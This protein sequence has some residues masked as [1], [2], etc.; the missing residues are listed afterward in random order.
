MSKKTLFLIFALFLIAFTLL[1]V[2]IYQPQAPKT[3]QVTPTPVKKIISQS[4]LSFGSPSLDASSSASTPTYSYP[5]NISTGENKVTAVQLE[6][7]YDPKIMTDVKVI[8]GPFFKNPDTLLNQ[9]DAATGRISYALSVGLTAQGITGTGT[10]AN[11]TFSVKDKT[12]EKVAIIFLPK[13]LIT[14]TG[15]TQSVLKQTTNGLFT[16]VKESSTPSAR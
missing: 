1:I 15:E 2:A 5:V 6:L 3:T 8:P 7:Q 14:A 4:A 13:T 11:I 10:V 9:I 12:A 16:I